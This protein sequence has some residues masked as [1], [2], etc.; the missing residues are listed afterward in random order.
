M[1]HIVG[2][3][4]DHDNALRLE[5]QSAR[6][7]AKASEDKLNAERDFARMSEV[8]KQRRRQLSAASHDIRQPLDR[9][10]SSSIKHR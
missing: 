9:Y 2:I 10:S 1:A 4:R 8:A 5:L 7:A 6:R 3:Q